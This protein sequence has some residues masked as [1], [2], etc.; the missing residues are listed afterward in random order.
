MDFIDKPMVRHED[1]KSPDSMSGQDLS[2]ED[3]GQDPD[4]TI[5][6]VNNV[7]VPLVPA[8]RVE[9]TVQMSSFYNDLMINVDDL[10][11][12]AEDNARP[13]NDSAAVLPMSPME[14]MRQGPDRV[15]G[16]MEAPTPA[17]EHTN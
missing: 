7:L 8:T 4:G 9:D 3:R 15:V 11:T 17:V 5:G 1:N 6:D 16:D 2:P 14:H 10:V 12:T 13:N